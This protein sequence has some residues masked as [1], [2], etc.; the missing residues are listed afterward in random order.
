[1]IHRK[2]ALLVNSLLNVIAAIFFGTCGL[3]NSVEML[4]IGRFIVG[5]GAG[6]IPF[7]FYDYKN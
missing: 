1:M 3:A 6:K 2:N 7:F 5:I 4:L